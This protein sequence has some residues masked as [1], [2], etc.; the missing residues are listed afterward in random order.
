MWPA[1]ELYGQTSQTDHGSL[2]A[3]ERQLVC[4]Q[5]R[6]LCAPRP[7]SAQDPLQSHMLACRY[8]HIRAPPG[9]LSGAQALS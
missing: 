3:V 2:V 8:R 5:L 9:V 1:I 4:S 7:A 6:A